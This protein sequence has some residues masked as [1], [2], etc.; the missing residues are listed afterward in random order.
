MFGRVIEFK[1]FGRVDWIVRFLVL[2]ED[3]KIRVVEVDGVFGGDGGEVGV[4][5]EEEGVVYD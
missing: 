4:W 5:V 3:Y 1:V 2:V